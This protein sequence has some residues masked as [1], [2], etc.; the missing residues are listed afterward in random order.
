MPTVAVD[1]VFLLACAGSIGV[2][3]VLF[4]IGCYLMPLRAV[5]HAW[6]N[7]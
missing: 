4:G 3:V 1:R 5:K 6:R 2:G 7:R